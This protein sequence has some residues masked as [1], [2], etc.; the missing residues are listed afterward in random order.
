MEWTPKW[1][2][3]DVTRRQISWFKQKG[4]DQA[5]ETLDVAK[6]TSFSE[7]DFEFVITNF[8]RKRRMF[9]ALQKSL[10]NGRGEFKYLLSRVSLY[11]S[12]LKFCND[13]N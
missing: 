7:S 11:F 2:V 12:G 3:L 13:T 1:V 6:V 5:E 8:A 9:S 4:D 10:R